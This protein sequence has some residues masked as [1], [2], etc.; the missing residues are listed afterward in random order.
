MVPRKKKKPR[1]LVLSGNGINCELET[2]HANRLVGFDVDIVHISALM[3]GTKNI[4]DYDFLNL[5]GGFLDG[6]DL[7]AGKAQAVKWRYQPIKGTE[8]KFIDELLK[9][10]SDGKLIIGICNGFQLLTKTGLLPGLKGDYQKQSTTL[11]FNDSGRFE[12]RWVYLKVNT[13]SSCIFTKDIDKIY[14][15]VRHG[16]GKLVV[17]D[18]KDVAQLTEDG[19]VVMQY[20][21]EDGRV[22]NDFPYN[23]NGSTLSI[24]SLCDPSGRIFGLMPHPEAFVHYTQH[25]RWT[26]ERLPAEGDGLKI[27]R[28]AYK[29]ILD[30]R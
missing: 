21:D 13:F 14:L 30:N 4:H 18:K 20:C 22:T 17:A 9:F 26:R 25:P 11:T 24:A 1:S 28:N 2:A 7:G 29:Y 3:E 6:D 5:P 19:H 16:E 10:V 15:P 27:F 12:D 23:P 8:K